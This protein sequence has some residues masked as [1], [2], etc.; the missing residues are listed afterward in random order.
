M[1]TY[2]MLLTK[3]NCTET[4]QPVT[5]N[6]YYATNIALA[7]LSVVIGVFAVGLNS[8]VIASVSKTPSLRRPANLLL[9]SIAASDLLVGLVVLPT[10]VTARLLK[11]NS[12]V[13]ICVADFVWNLYSFFLV[14]FSGASLV[15]LCVMSWDRYKAV[16]DPMVYRANV[17]K[18]KTLKSIAV[19]WLMWATLTI[20]L[21]FAVPQALSKYILPPIGAVLILVPI[22]SQVAMY[23]AIRR[24]NQQIVDINSQTT[25]VALA[26]EKKIAV[27]L[28]YVLT[29]LLVCLLMPVIVQIVSVAIGNEKFVTYGVPWAISFVFLNSCINPVIYFLRHPEMRAG[30]RSVF[31]C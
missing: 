4:V 10:Y 8:S 27:T 1:T 30:V 19:S 16:S 13:S 18:R 26:R 31:G 29:A 22:A 7:V 24:H 12:G 2:T 15:Q 17:S 21:K 6:I 5:D 23:K 9:C 28:R 25:A 11:I 20:L 3:S 14:L